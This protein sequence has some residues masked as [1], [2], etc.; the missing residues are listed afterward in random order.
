VDPY[1]LRRRKEDL[2]F[3]VVRFLRAYDLFAGIY[4]D[5]R[6]AAAGGQ[7]FGG[8][9]LFLR[10]RELEEKL[11]FDI[12]EK[13]H[14]LFRGHSSAGAPGFQGASPEGRYE[15]LER[16]LAGGQGGAGGSQSREILAGLRHSLVDR[17]LDSNIGTGFHM[18]L[19]LREC[20]YQLEVYAPRYEAELEQAKRLEYLARRIGFGLGEEE[21]HE[22]EH[23]RQLVKHGQGVAANAR[24]LAERALERCRALFRETAELLRHFIEEAG[25]NEV[26]V[27]NLLREREALERVYGEGAAERLFEHMFRNSGKPGTSGLAKA[28]AFARKNCGNTEALDA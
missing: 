9:G 28:L 6:K 5:F 24:E 4:R 20:L 18:F 25:G 7:G 10:V 14:F 8:S 3:L 23:I 26:L 21:A 13:A 19:I 2:S 12:K 22:L 11:V 15:E 16:L 1:L 27:L 17:S